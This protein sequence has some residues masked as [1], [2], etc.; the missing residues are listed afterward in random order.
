MHPGGYGRTYSPVSYAR[1]VPVGR[2]RSLH[3]QA[4][5][6]LVA[7][8]KAHCWKHLQQPMGQ[9]TM[10]IRLEVKTAKPV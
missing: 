3:S 7:C 10:M 2:P 5:G 4:S 8:D 6:L 1:G 9:I